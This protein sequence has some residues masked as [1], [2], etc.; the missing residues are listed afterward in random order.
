MEDKT[1][2]REKYIKKVQASQ[3]KKLSFNIKKLSFEEL[4]SG[5]IIILII[6]LLIGAY[7]RLYRIADYLTFL[8]DEGRDV[9][10]VKRM[11]VDKK[12]TLL[13]P[14][15]SVGG[16]F[17]GP[18]YYYFMLP[19]LWLWRLDPVGPAI[20]VALFGVATI[21]LIY[22]VGKEFFNEKT[23]LL[24]S[25]LYAFSP[26]VIAY[27]RSS[28]NPN[29]VPFFSLLYIYS[30]GKLVKEKRWFWWFLA[31]LTVG[32]GLQLHY[33][34]TFL[35]P[36]GFSY[37]FLFK[38]GK[39]F[40]KK[41]G[42]FILGFLIGLAPFLAFEI[43]HRFTNIQTIIKFLF[44][45]KETGFA[46]IKTIVILGDLIFRLFGRLIFYFPPPEQFSLYSKNILFWWRFFVIMAVIS[47]LAYLVV[48]IIKDKKAVHIL[49]LLWFV[50][51]IGLFSFYKKDIYDYY[52]GILFPLPFLLLGNLF[53]FFWQ[54]KILKLFVGIGF[55]ALLI[56]NWS[57]RPFKFPANR[58][59]EQAKTISRF[60]L[61]KTENKPF[62]FALITAQN[63]DHAYRYFLEIW[64]RKPIII[65]NSQIDPEKKTVADQ[66]LIV[67]EDINCQPLGHSLWEVAGF[68]RA[69]IAGQWDVSVVKIYKLIHY[70]EESL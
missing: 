17:L 62:N 68:G 53:S 56:F 25:S 10:V 4:A 57:G 35:I 64:D 55:T 40:I 14:T 33:L 63:S 6:I 30:L 44:T 37:I 31:G 21:F 29:L 38:R 69:E 51:G 2:K 52:L 24:A 48:R 15:A 32:I 26:L 60:V 7:L 61:E 1:L 11:I 50:F 3:G 12:F 5:K 34:F 28:W 13:G 20:M 27:S 41:Y 70:Q 36:I 47:S 45:G 43:R 66:L 42:L 46:E 65:E 22:Q 18:I 54:K 19:F 23:G 59:L 16:F 8:G 9:L 49:I 58:Q 39:P 67:C